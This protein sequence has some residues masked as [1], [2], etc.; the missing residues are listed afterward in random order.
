MILVP[1]PTL[2]MSALFGVGIMGKLQLIAQPNMS[3]AYW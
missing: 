2:E 3:T 1:F